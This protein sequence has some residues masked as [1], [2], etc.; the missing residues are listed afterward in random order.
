[1]TAQKLRIG[2]VLNLPI[3]AVTQTFV[4]FG[5]RGSGKSN[6]GVV[7]AEE[8]LKA[9]ARFTALDPV[10]HWWGLKARPDGSPGFPVYVFGGPRR[11]LPLEP[12]AGALMAQVSAESRS[13]MVLCTVEFSGQERARFVADF[14]A[15]LLKLML[16]RQYAPLHLFLEEADAFAPQRPFKGEE[17]MLG[18]VDKFVRQS[19]QGGAGVSMITQRSAA[20][21]KNVTTQAETL[22]AFRTLGPQ[23]RDAIDEWIRFHESGTRRKEVL[24]TLA[25]LRDGESWLWSPEWLDFFGRVQWRRRETFDAAAT[26]KVGERVVQPKLADVDIEQLRTKMAA[27]IERAKADDP[28]ELRRR[29]AQLEKERANEQQH[30]LVQRVAIPG[31]SELEAL[32]QLLE[33]AVRRANE[34]AIHVS[35]LVDRV[36][37]YEGEVASLDA[38]VGRPIG[39]PGTTHSRVHADVPERAGRQSGNVAAAPLSPHNDKERSDDVSGPQ[40]R[41]LDALARLE[42]VGVREPQKT[43]VALF[44]GASPTSSA[45]SN[46]LGALRTAGLIHYPGPGRAALTPGGRAQAR[47]VEVPVSSAELQE[48]VALLVGGPKWRILKVLIDRYP[49]A[50]EKSELAR[51]AEASPTSSAFGNNLG[52][53]RSLGFLDYPQPGYAAAEPVLFVDEAMLAAAGG[54][55]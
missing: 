11:D 27:T 34:L 50:V 2:N 54:G 8:I 19:R 14:M 36:D 52:A 13:S 35:D 1:V 21:N 55:R 29:I 44:A 53:L 37:W 48:Q 3:E 5:K 20:L 16:S 26:P 31:A 10:G 12:T 51:M 15:E 18:A 47:A 41:I 6:A 17:R 4:Y 23:D 28:R 40:Q 42:A 43:Q 46:N 25:T 7:L 38:N 24:E 45:F 22:V 39:S 9:G 30:P 33:D 49:R 32:R